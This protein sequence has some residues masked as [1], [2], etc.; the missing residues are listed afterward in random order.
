MKADQLWQGALGELQ[1]QLE[2]PSFDTW[3]NGTQ[4]I[5]YEDGVLVVGVKSGYAKDWLENRLYSSIQKTVTQIAGR[6]VSVRFVVRSNSHAPTPQPTEPWDSPEFPDDGMDDQD[7]LDPHINRRYTFD[8][9][10]VGQS[11]RLAHAGCLAVSE[12]PGTSY[13]PL[14]IYGGVGL[15]KTHLLHAIGNQAMHD[16]RRTLYVS[17]E[18]FAN[19]LDRKSVV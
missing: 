13:N 4:A 10:I 9:F 15:G 6:T 2:R 16:N 1:M 19:E 12:N 14:F 8:N 7:D 18:T 5:S 3:V 11:N 17:A